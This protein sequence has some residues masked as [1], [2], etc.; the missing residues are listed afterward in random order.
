VAGIIE[1]TD[2]LATVPSRV[3]GILSQGRNMKI[4]PLPFPVP[5]Y[6]VT[7]TWHERFSLDPAHQWLRAI[8]AGLYKDEGAVP[9]VAKRPMIV[10]RG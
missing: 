1:V 4:M 2:F 10:K 5:P 6:T 8:M 7:Q 9:P 3:G